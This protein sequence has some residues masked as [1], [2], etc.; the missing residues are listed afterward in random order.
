MSGRRK[1]VHS[2]LFN[3]VLEVLATAIRQEKEIRH[4]HIGKEVKLLLFADDMI[5][6]MVNP[7]ESTKTFLEVWIKKMW[8]IYIQWNNIQ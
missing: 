3:I 4:I 1:Y 2:H 8:Y 6:Y 5:L 7:K